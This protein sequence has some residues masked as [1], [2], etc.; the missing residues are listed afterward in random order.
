MAGAWLVS[1]FP[2]VL[3]FRGDVSGEDGEEDHAC[4]SEDDGEDLSD[5]RDAEDVGTD[6][7]DVHERPVEGIPVGFHGRIYI[8]FHVVED[9]AAKVNRGEQDGEVGDKQIRDLAAGHPADDKRY[10]VYTPGKRD[11][12]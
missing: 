10:P 5:F 12:A 1:S 2:L 8:M 11:K 9:D 4:G 3:E 7:S 6:G